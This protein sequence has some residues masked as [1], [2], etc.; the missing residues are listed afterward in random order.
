MTYT[1]ILRT[2]LYCPNS[3][4]DKL[5]VTSV[6]KTNADTTRANPV[7]KLTSPECVTRIFDNKCKPTEYNL[8]FGMTK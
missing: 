7:D 2:R 4:T 3:S 1:V 8:S 6:I 5:R